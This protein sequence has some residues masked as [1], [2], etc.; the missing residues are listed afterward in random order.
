[1][2]VEAV[3]LPVQHVV[4]YYDFFCRETVGN[5]LRLRAHGNQQLILGSWDHGTIGKSRVGDV[6]FGP[7]AQIDLAGENLAWFDRFLKKSITAQFPPVR[8]FSMG[9]NAWRSAESWPPEGTELAPLYLQSEGHANTR[10]G[11]G[12]LSWEAPRA[13]APPDR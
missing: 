12:R 7:A 13:G 4:G 3:R 8:Y 11:D 10:R 6:D 2:E 9:E 1:K 5:F